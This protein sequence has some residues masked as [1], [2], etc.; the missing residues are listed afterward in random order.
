MLK[1][2]FTKNGLPYTL[3]KRNDVVAQYSGADYY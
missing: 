2:H 1:E 3:L